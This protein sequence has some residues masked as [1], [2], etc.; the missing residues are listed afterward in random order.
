VS[1][2]AIARGRFMMEESP[3]QVANVIESLF[4]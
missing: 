2:G 4:A 3:M 1:G